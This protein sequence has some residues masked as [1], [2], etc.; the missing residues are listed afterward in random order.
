[1][2]AGIDFK[3]NLVLWL[4][5]SHISRCP[6]CPLGGSGDGFAGASDQFSTF[7]FTGRLTIFE[8]EYIHI[9]LHIIYI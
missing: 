6:I 1:M 8:K 4:A 9:Y 2:D 5:E 7:A 3:V